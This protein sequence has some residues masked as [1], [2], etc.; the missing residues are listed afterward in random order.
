MLIAST[1]THKPDVVIFSGAG[2][3]T[4]EPLSKKLQG[5]AF[6]VRSF[7]LSCYFHLTSRLKSSKVSKLRDETQEQ[8]GKGTADATDDE[9]DEL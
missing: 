1:S 2:P 6:M 7:L 5:K 9:D 4:S 8:R 3:K